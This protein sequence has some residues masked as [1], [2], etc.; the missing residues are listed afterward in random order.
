MTHTI[1]MRHWY[2]QLLAFCFPPT[3]DAALAQRVDG[4]TLRRSFRRDDFRGIEIL[5]RYRDRAIGACIRQLKYRGDRRVAALFGE[6]LRTVVFSDLREPALLVPM[7]LSRERYR[8]RG[9]NQVMNVAEAI[10]HHLLRVEEGIL[11][12][13]HAV[14]QTKLRKAERHVNLRGV[15]QISDREKLKGQ[16]VILLDDVATTGATMLAAR[17]MLLEGGARSVRCI[18]LAH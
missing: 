13:A 9:Y 17:K 4:P 11:T 3:E 1:H 15:F 10:G 7:P 8:E 2:E 18:A 6:L 5:F 14:S 12:R 16:N